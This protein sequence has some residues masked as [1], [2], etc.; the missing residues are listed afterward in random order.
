MDIWNIIHYQILD[1]NAANNYIAN[2]PG[3]F[4]LIFEEWEGISE[5]IG[6]ETNYSAESWRCIRS[7]IQQLLAI[8][9]NEEYVAESQDEG[10]DIGEYYVS[11]DSDEGVDIEDE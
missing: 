6:I 2:H 8:L 5:D 4:N 7:F 11:E 3:A 10:I 1:L 9:R